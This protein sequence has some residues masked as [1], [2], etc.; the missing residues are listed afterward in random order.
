M[1]SL[2][3]LKARSLLAI[4]L[5]VSAGCEER[6]RYSVDVVSFEIDGVDQPL[7]SELIVQLGE[8]A[9]S[10]R[11]SGGVEDFWL[12]IEPLGVGGLQIDTFSID[13]PPLYEPLRYYLA[14]GGT[15]EGFPSLPL[16]LDERYTLGAR[17]CAY[18]ANPAFV[19]SVSA[20]HHDTRLIRLEVARHTGPH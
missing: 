8:S 14:R 5:A 4:A 2:V 16:R 10:L 1:H 11:P 7:P 19:L 3:K 17:A 6:G 18:E 13:C 15:R 20:R 12:S 9:L